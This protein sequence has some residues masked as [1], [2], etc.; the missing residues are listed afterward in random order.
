MSTEIVDIVSKYDTAHV[1]TLDAFERVF[2]LTYYNNVLL[3][4]E[5]LKSTIVTCF[6]SYVD[7]FSLYVMSPSLIWDS[8]IPHNATKSL[9]NYS[10][11]L[12]NLKQ[13]KG[14]ATHYA[15]YL[16]RS[17]LGF[18]YYAKYKESNKAKFVLA[19]KRLIEKSLN[20]DN[21]Y[22]KLRAATFFFTH[23]EYS[24][25]IEMCDTFLTF[26]PRRTL[27]IYSYH[28]EEGV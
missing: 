23:L 13:V 1:V 16:V 12:Q 6:N 26:L 28:M 11:I 25:S 22:V 18:L 7:T 20:L 15:N 19:S 27:L 4:N 9:M 8:Y 24:Q 21:S 2:K 17:M 5:T 3:K 10:S 14:V